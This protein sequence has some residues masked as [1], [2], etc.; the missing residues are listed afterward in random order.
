MH[1]GLSRIYQ[2]NKV[3][4]PAVADM[5][6]HCEDLVHAERNAASAARAMAEYYEEMAELTR[7]SK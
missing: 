5:Q 7:K 4:S 1:D 3:P 6:K 2:F